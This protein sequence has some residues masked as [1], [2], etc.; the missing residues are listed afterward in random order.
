M[1]TCPHCG[2]EFTKPAANPHISQCVHKP[3]N[4]EAARKLADSGNGTAISQYKYKLRAAAA[5][6]P[7]STILLR[8][9]GGWTQ[10]M[11]FLGLRPRNIPADP[12]IVAE[13]GDEIQEAIETT[14]QALYVSDW[15]L[16]VCGVRETEREL[17]F[18][19]K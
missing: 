10:A 1:I 2:R 17:F 14:R 18:M 7:S 4:R 3:E 6:A 16:Q 8:T 9:F 13:I 11:A 19:L 12:A 15:P 5:G